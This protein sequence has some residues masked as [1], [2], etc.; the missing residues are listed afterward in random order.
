MVALNIMPNGLSG[1]DARRHDYTFGVMVQNLAVE[2][3]HIVHVRGNPAEFLA[4]G[5]SASTFPSCNCLSLM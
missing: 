3:E 4:D 2:A 1:N 5:L